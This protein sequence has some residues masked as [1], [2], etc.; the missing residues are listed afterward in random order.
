MLEQNPMG[1]MFGFGPEIPLVTNYESQPIVTDLKNSFTGF[2]V[3][4][5]LADQEHGQGDK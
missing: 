4:R 1:Q 2:P 3:A 5:S